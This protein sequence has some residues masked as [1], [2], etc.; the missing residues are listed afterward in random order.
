MLNP[1]GRPSQAVQT[2]YAVSD[3]RYSIQDGLRRPCYIALLLVLLAT[4]TANAQRSY[5][6]LMNLSPTAAQVGQSSEHTV[7]SRYSM[8]GANQVLVSGDGVTG[9]VVTPMELARMAKNPR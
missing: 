9:E 5:P 8:F 2:H 6:M 4:Q 3:L 1:V 7:E